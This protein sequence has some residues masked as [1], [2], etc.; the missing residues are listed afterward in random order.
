MIVQRSELPK[1]LAC[2]A[3]VFVFIFFAAAKAAAAESAPD[4][5]MAIAVESDTRTTG[6]GATGPRLVDESSV[7]DLRNLGLG[8]SNDLNENA[9]D[10]TNLD[11]I[12]G[13]ASQ[14]Y[15]LHS[16]PEGLD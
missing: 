15:H 16:K 10:F 8:M 7:R 5:E 12:P 13:F 4:S 14:P 3:T 6:V 1:P 2:L 9:W 11:S